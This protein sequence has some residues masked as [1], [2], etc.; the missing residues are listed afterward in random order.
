MRIPRTFASVLLLAA[1]APAGALFAD[2]EPTVE[3]LLEEAERE[4][5]TIV[6]QGERDGLR[7]RA[8]HR[9]DLPR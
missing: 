6:W 5:R 1:L 4:G 8:G 3:E 7:A 2:G 9:R